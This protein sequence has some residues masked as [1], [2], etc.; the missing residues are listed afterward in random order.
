LLLRVN[1]KDF[2]ALFFSSGFR[3]KTLWMIN[4]RTKKEIFEWG[5][6]SPA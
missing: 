3:K 6:T 1:H 5:E 2:L 4:I